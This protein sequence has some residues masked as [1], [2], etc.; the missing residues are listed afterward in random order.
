MKFGL[1]YRI[2]ALAS[3]LSQRAVSAD[4]VLTECATVI[5]VPSGAARVRMATYGANIPTGI[6]SRIYSS[7]ERG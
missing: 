4:N 2:S 1:A 7:V 6:T 3:A 5:P